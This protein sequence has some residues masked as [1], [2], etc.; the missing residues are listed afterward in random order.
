MS[1]SHAPH[2]SLHSHA[3]HP[4][5]SPAQKIAWTRPEDCQEP[6]AVDLAEA[7]LGAAHLFKQRGNLC[8]AQAEPGLS[9][10]SVPRARLLAAVVDAMEAGQERIRMG[11]LTA[12]L[13]VT[14]R[15]ITTI[16]D[17]LEREG[18]LARKRDST[19]RRAILLELT[20]KGCAHVERIHALQRDLAERMFAP[21]NSHERQAL[22]A[23]L[24]RLVRHMSQVPA[25]A[26]NG[27]EEA[28]A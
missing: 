16:V 17:G 23:L 3:S 4:N 11:D 22:H 20:E 10:L 25:S 9:E 18:L 5:R 27:R 21:L 14:A 2:P 26:T 19:D 28:P 8:F 13:G 7:L 1:R 6:G 12:A 15:N 24:A